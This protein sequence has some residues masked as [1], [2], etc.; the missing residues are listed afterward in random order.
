MFWGIG[1]EGVIGIV[2]V[3]GLDSVVILI[4][5]RLDRVIK[6]VIR[7]CMGSVPERMLLEKE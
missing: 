1:E 7:V 6:S 5:L 2:V 3:A 4:V